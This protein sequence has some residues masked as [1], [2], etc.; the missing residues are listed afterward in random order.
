MVLGDLKAPAL[1]DHGDEVLIVVNCLAEA[2]VVVE[3]LLFGHLKQRDP[4]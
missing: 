4:R 3:E 1:V 2:G